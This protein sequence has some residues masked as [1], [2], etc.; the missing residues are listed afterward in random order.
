HEAPV[1]AHDGDAKAARVVVA[2]VGAGDVDAG[3]RRLAGLE[4]A[5][6]DVGI[7]ICIIGDQ[8]AG[9]TLERHESSIGAD[10]RGEAGAIVAAAGAAAVDAD[11]SRRAGL[12]VAH[13]DLNYSVRRSRDHNAADQNTRDDPS[14]SADVW[15]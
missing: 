3:H 15:Q 7:E 11:Q 2:A 13:E 12:D 4:V 1:D 14:A 10:G 8:I 5:H 9:F 6:E